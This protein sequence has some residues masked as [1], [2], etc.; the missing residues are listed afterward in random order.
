[1]TLQSA[2]ESPSRVKSYAFVVVATVAVF[3]ENVTRSYQY[4]IR[5]ETVVTARTIVDW[6]VSIGGTY[7]LIPG[8]LLVVYYLLSGFGPTLSLT[9]RFLLGLLAGVLAGSLLG[10][11]VGVAP[12]PLAFVMTSETFAADPVTVRLWFDVLGSI[13]REFLVVLGILA[14]AR[15]IR[16]RTWDEGDTGT[17]R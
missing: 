9:G 2:L 10:Q 3:L 15:A 1:M 13:S 14:L 7:L 16:H 8:L 5:E 4:S 6:V 11:S 12:H 17:L